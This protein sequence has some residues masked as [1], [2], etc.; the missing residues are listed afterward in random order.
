MRDDG[1]PEAVC[2][3]RDDPNE[4]CAAP[5]S[6]PLFEIQTSLVV[7][8]AR[9]NQSRAAFQR[10]VRQIVTGNGNGSEHRGEL[11]SPARLGFTKSQTQSVMMSHHNSEA[12]F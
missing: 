1:Q 12:L 7:G 10:L 9:F 3:A 5:K 8:S 4:K 6:G 2:L 11:L